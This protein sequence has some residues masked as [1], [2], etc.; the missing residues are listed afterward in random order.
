MLIKDAKTVKGYMTLHQKNTQLF[1][2]APQHLN[3]DLFVLISIAKGIGQGSLLG[4][5][6]WNFGD[7]W[8]WHFRK[9]D[10]NIQIIAR[11]VRF[12]ATPDTP[13]ANAVK[14]AYTDSVMFSL[15]IIARSPAAPMSST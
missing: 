2:I 3:K 5:M 10:K 13:E 12:V 8:I 6:S 1:A 11:N 7:D 4:G 15:P 9:V 14:L